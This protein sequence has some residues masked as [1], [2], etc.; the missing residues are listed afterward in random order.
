MGMGHIVLGLS[1]CLSGI[2]NIAGMS[3]Q[4]DSQTQNNMAWSFDPG[5]LNAVYLNAI[6]VMTTIYIK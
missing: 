1:V 6:S 4:L 2:F 3:A 5:H